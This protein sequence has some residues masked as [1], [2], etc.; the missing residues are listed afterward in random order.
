MSAEL[1][2]SVATL[3]NVKMNE[4]ILLA[5]RM[6]HWAGCPE[7]SFCFLQGPILNSQRFFLWPAVSPYLSGFSFPHLGHGHGE[8]AAL[9]L[10]LPETSA[11]G[12]QERLRA[13]LPWAAGLRAQQKSNQPSLPRLERKRFPAYNWFW[14]EHQLEPVGRNS[15][16]KKSFTNVTLKA[17]VGNNTFYLILSS[18]IKSWIWPLVLAT[19]TAQLH[20]N[21]EKE[22]NCFRHGTGT[23]SK[24]C[25][26]KVQHYSA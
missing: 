6:V 16:R 17:Q 13:R 12:T 10:R 14:E 19:S 9:W 1:A 11:H 4:K 20:T 3:A 8:I 25:W 24:S 7:H 26:S 18:Y 5:R 21:E 2:F 22:N 15:L 23:P